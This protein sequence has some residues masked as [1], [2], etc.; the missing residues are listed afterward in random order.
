M[1]LIVVAGAAACSPPRLKPEASPAPADRPIEA[2]G[3]EIRVLPNAWRGYPSWLP[4][5]F[6]PMWL[7]FIN[8][9]GESFDVTYA[10]MSLVDETGN[11]H[12]AIPPT[13]VSRELMGALD[14]GSSLVL[15]P[16]Q[17]QQGEG[18]PPPEPPA[19]S[20]P[21]RIP[22]PE[23]LPPTSAPTPPLATGSVPPDDPIYFG[24]APYEFAFQ[25]TGS[26]A[27]V[28]T[29]RTP[30]GYQAPF[31][32]FG[33]TGISRDAGD[34][35]TPALREGRLLPNTHA[36]GFV[37]FRANHGARRLELRLSAR[38]ERQDGKSLE[39][40]VPFTYR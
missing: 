25:G 26:T 39:V 32:P 13:L 9:G 14:D 20:K 18:P 8:R 19:T 11:S 6:T 2:Q 38:N 36:E 37:Y 12:P 31:S 22:A 1:A 24:L 35:V 17:A 3:V 30:F 15:V 40:V 10:S 4:Q 34:I 33:R 21:P 27:S 29:G 23:P 16:V 5:R 28:G 7:Y